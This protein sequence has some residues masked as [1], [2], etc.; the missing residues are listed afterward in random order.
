MPRPCPS[1]RGWRRS[2]GVR[3]GDVCHAHT[4]ACPFD[5]GKVV[6]RIADG[7]HLGHR[8]I[9]HLCEMRKTGALVHARGHEFEI[10]LGR[11]RDLDPKRFAMGARCGSRPC[12]ASKSRFTYRIFTISRPSRNDRSGWSALEMWVTPEIKLRYARSSLSASGTKTWPSATLMC[13]HRPSSRPLAYSS[14]AQARERPQ[15]L[16]ASRRPRG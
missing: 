5:H 12:S 14:S 13:M 7:D 11:E 16:R 2:R 3:L 8:N 4:Q 10:A 9:Q 15:V 1:S 6:C